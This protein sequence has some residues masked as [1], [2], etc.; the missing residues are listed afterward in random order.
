MKQ[1]YPRM[2][3]EYR[4][5]LYPAAVYVSPPGQKELDSSREEMNQ[6]R[7]KREAEARRRREERWAKLPPELREREQQAEEEQ[8]AILKNETS[9]GPCQV[10]NPDY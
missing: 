2:L 6:E 8:Q 5:G 9:N 10:L 3:Y 4:V 1:S 7:E